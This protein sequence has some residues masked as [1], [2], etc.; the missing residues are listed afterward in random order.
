[1]NA[2]SDGK[3]FNVAVKAFQFAGDTSNA[4]ASQLGRFLH[5]PLV[6]LLPA[7]MDD[8]RDLRHF[9]PQRVAQSGAEAAEKAH[10]MNAVADD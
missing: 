10:R 6:R 1:M 3:K 9:A 7:F 5:H 2:R 4:D 8:V